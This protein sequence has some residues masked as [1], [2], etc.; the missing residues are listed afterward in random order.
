[1]IRELTQRQKEFFVMA[2][3]G[4]TYEQISQYAHVEISTV[5]S[6]FA[7]ARTRLNTSTTMQCLVIAISR[8]EIGIDHNGVAFLP[9]MK[10]YE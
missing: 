2:A 3:R 1:M 10:I 6:T 9:D 8:E 4:M 7:K 5:K